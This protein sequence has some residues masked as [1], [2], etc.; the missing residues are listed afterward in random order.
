[1]QRDG[2]LTVLLIEDS[3]DYAG[4]LAERLR[5]RVGYAVIHRSRLQDGEE[6]LAEQGVDC[7]LLD[8]GLPDS[9]GLTAVHRLRAD[10]PHV[11]LVILSGRRDDRLAGQAVH[12]GAQD[13]LYKAETD[14]TLI[15][16]AIRYAIER[17]GAQQ[18][19]TRQ[20]LHDSLTGLPN[21]LLFGDR[22]QVA[23]AQA[24]RRGGGVGVLFLDLDNFKTVNDSLGHQAGDEL[25]VEVAARLADAVR[26][27]DTVARFGGDEFV[28]LCE[29]VPDV[30]RLHEIARRIGERVAMELEL[31]GRVM[32]VTPSI[33]MTFD[34][35]GERT[36]DDLLREADAAMYRAK[37]QA[38]FSF[39]LFH[40]DMHASAMARLDLESELHRA[41]AS[42]ELE[43]HWQP[44]V[45]LADGTLQSIEAL[46]RWNHPDRG[47][48]RPSEF[49]PVAEE[50]GLIVPLGSWVLR[51]ACRQLRV[52]RRDSGRDDLRISI[53]VAPLQLARQDLVTVV[54]G[55]ARGAGVPAGA[56]TL[57]LTET[58][59]LTPSP[60]SR[61]NLAGLRRLGCSISLDDFGMGYSSLGVLTELPLQ[62]LK[63]DRHFVSRMHEDEGRRRIVTALT[64]L[65]SAL[66]LHTVAEGVERAE[67]IDELRAAGCGV[68]Q[69]FALSPPVPAADVA[70]W[71]GGGWRFAREP[72][73]RPVDGPAAVAAPGS[74]FPASPE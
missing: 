35:C 48:L 26:P 66:G 54:D 4:L 34:P 68:A 21:R 55:A 16:R 51:E 46:V 17:A 47:L 71:L 31:G 12:A 22:L 70:P 69:G 32:H 53:N 65:S 1:V 23:L 5:R 11:P 14:P 8:L 33:G 36:P 62:E 74:T 6:V 37:R 3:K 2:A 56:L 73:A 67:Q 24:G 20:A 27:G 58:G 72:G 44:Q 57:E 28:V 7:V 49:I 63:I 40:R 39:E 52:W 19:M 25:L 30:L 61:A 43:L 42:D 59:V 15:G 64:G 29:D 50:T 10:F 41:L 45:D 9:D 60:R 38:G 13:Y 18:E